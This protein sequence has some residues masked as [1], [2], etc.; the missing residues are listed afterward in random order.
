MK[1]LNVPQSGSQADTTAS[2]NRFGQYLR[3]RAMPTQPRTAAQLA[4]RSNL[5]EV[6]AAWRG[7]T[8]AQRVA[9]NAYAQAHPRT[10]SLGQSVKLT[11]HMAFNAVNVLNLLIEVAIQ[12]AVPDDTA[13]ATPEI[14]VDDNSHTTFSLVTSAAVPNDTKIVVYASPPLSPGRSFNGDFRIV[15]HVMG[16]P[17]A[18]QSLVT[19]EQLA[20]KYGT[21]AA[22]QKFFFQV[23]LVKGGNVSPQ[24]TANVV[25]S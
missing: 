2:R 1:Q 5:T 10:D 23:I 20:N 25:L 3:T 8:D 7:L 19:A 6:S 22:N 15:N 17:S 11:G 9:W 12:T 13:I 4:V 21:L 14:S 24:A 18:G 16:S